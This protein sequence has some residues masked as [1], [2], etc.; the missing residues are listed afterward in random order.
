M[1]EFIIITLEITGTFGFIAG[2]ADSLHRGCE[3]NRISK[4]LPTYFLGC[5]IFK[6]RDFE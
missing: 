1:K 5:E 4:L 2:S 3:Y 6:L